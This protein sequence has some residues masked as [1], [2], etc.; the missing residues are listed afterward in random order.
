MVSQPQ[1]DSLVP[2]DPLIFEMNNK[3]WLIFAN[4]DS[5]NEMYIF[6]NDDPIYG[7]W[8]SHNQNP[9]YISSHL[10]RNAGL[11]F[12]EEKIY[13]IVQQSGLII[14]KSMKIMKINQITEDVFLEESN[15][16]TGNLTDHQKEFILYLSLVNL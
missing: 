2:V 7:E 10:S 3:W 6:Y 13:R 16:L 8:K 11:I 14:M 4:L 1:F 15:S 12:D 5:L 9:V